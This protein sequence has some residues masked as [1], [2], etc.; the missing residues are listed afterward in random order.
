MEVG[1]E[2]NFRWILGTLGL[3]TK[4]VLSGE[5]GLWCGNKPLPNHRSLPQQKCVSCS[6][7]SVSLG[8][9]PGQLSFL[10]QLRNPDCFSLMALSP[11]CCGRGRSCMK[12]HSS[13]LTFRWPS[14]VQGPVSCKVVPCF[15]LC[16]LVLQ[17]EKW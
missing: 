3:S 15:V 12:S 6:E 7:S 10:Q 5:V 13:P 1:G 9:A 17:K 8:D 14:H 2:F 16:A 4:R 11:D